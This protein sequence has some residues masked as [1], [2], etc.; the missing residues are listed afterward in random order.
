MKYTLKQTNNSKQQ[1][2]FQ[3]FSNQ[4]Y[5]NTIKINKTLKVNEYQINDDHQALYTLLINK[6]KH[7]QKIFILGNEKKQ[8][9]NFLLDYKKAFKFFHSYVYFEFNY[10]NHHYTFYYIL[11]KNEG[12]KFP[13]YDNKKQVALIEKSFYTHKNLDAYQISTIDNL[14]LNIVLLVTIFIEICYFCNCNPSKLKRPNDYTYNQ[15]LLSK[16]HKDF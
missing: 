12:E 8:L 11:I 10:Q 6:T 7:K 2:T 15:T 1:I 4:T 13:I 16:Y 9:G 3:I 5:L 14:D